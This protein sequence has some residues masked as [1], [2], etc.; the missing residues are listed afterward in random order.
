MKTIVYFIFTCFISTGC[1]F[2]ALNAHNPFPF[3]A[4]AFGIWGL[5]LYGCKKRSERK[6]EQRR[7][8]RLL[9]TYMRHMMRHLK[10]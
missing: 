4:V 9:E 5:F 1:M 2:G 8:E 7:R 3:F 10:R 6:A